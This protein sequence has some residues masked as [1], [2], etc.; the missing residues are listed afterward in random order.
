MKVKIDYDIF[1]SIKTSQQQQELLFLL[2]ILTYKQRYDLIIIDDVLKTNAYSNMS[3]SD[4]AI[5]NQSFIYSTI[6]SKKDFDCVVTKNGHIEYDDKK[7][8][9]EEAIRYLIQ[10]LSIIVENSSND[11]HFLLSVFRAFDVEKKLIHAYNNG[12]LQ[13]DNAGG[14]GNVLNLLES[15]RQFYAGKTK[16]LHCYILLDSDKRFPNDVNPKYNKLIKQ[17]QEW[18]I[19]YHILEKRCME[20]YLPEVAMEKILGNNDNNKWIKAYQSLTPI[21]KDYFCIAEGFSK[22]LTKANLKDVENE[23]KGKKYKKGLHKVSLV[24][25]YLPNDIKSLYQTVSEGNFIHL[26]KGLNIKGN[27]KDEYPK[28][29]DNIGYVYRKTLEQITAH[30]NNPQELTQISNEIKSIL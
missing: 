4:Q 6:A 29:F 27:F 20:N 9:L 2:N 11:A 25:K 3:K 22:D 30:Q 26:E 8:S 16:F 17:L 5:I 1:D 15:R 19:S 21:Q 12:W 10:P 24:R 18:K 7:F 14:C 13:F 28:A 23:K